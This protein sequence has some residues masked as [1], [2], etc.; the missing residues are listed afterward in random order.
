M[1]YRSQG[2]KIHDKHVEVIVRQMLRK[3]RVESPG[4]SELLPGELVDRVEYERINNSVL[5]EGGEPATASPVLL[6]VTRASL[7]TDSFLAA[8]S[9]QE[10]AR[11]L[12]EAAV[13]GSVDHLHGL[14]ENVIIGRLIP[15]RL[16]K[17]EA[18]R[19]RLGIKEGEGHREGTLTG[20]T[21]APATFEEALA[22]IGGDMPGSGQSAGFQPARANDEL[23]PVPSEAQLTA[24]T[25]D[26]MGTLRLDAK[27]ATD[28]EKSTA[29]KAEQ[30]VEAGSD[31]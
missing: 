13:N 25:E 21:Q 5:A 23:A 10:T 11:V 17:T 7:S 20:L 19:A 8:A 1:V 2:V 18:G 31:D 29:E 30:P 16:D 22:A 3:V 24:A 15:A 14:K 9:F 28:S 26:L 6:G 27:N 12:T 4:D